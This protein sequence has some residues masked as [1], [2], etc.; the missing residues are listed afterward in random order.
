[1]NFKYLLNIISA[2]GTFL[3]GVGTCMIGWAALNGLP[4]AAEIALEAAHQDY[5]NQVSKLASEVSYNARMLS[6]RNKLSPQIKEEALSKIKSLELEFNSV[7]GS[8]NALN[9]I[10]DTY[11]KATSSQLAEQIINRSIEEINKLTEP[12]FRRRQNPAVPH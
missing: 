12:I 11:Q 5:K 10:Y 8:T 4:K 9:E 2:V 7:I 6:P 1:M 3:L